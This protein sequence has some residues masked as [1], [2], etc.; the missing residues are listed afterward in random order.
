MKLSP[1]RLLAPVL[2][3]Q[4]FAGCAS[5]VV[6][7]PGMVISNQPN[8]ARVYR[9]IKD[10]DI[11]EEIGIIPYRDTIAVAGYK[12]T[13]GSMNYL[14]LYRGDTAIVRNGE[15]VPP[16]DLHATT[17]TLPVSADVGAWARANVYVVRNATMKI[18]EVT[19]VLVASFDA[20]VGTSYS[21]RRLPQGDSVQ[22]TVSSNKSQ[23][24]HRAA[25]YIQTGIDPDL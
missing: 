25:Y 24:A 10:H 11:G 13:R 17:F 18:Q 6:Y 4:L 15:V 3:C 14:I 19:P 22:Y 2:A 20:P 8:G 23:A 7:R 1:I 21:I 9:M 12:D 5:A 16:W